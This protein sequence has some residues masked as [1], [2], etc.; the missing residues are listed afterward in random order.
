MR[1]PESTARVACLFD[2]HGNLP[3]LEAVLQEVRHAG[4]DRVVVGGDVL[5]GPMP[6]QC[7]DLLSSLDT[8]TSFIL[9]NG[10]LAALDARRGVPDARIPAAFHQ[11]MAWNGAQLTDA[12]AQAIQA[13]PLTLT[14]SID[15]A[16]DVLFCHATPRDVNEIFLKTTAEEKL[17]PLFDPLCVALVVC[18]HT[19]M[20]FDR[21]A[22]PT[23]VVNAGSIGM[24]FQDAGA[25]WAV[26][27]PGVELRRTAYD[28]DSAAARVRAT[29][30]PHAELAAN[31]ILN[32][33]S[34]QATLEQF[35]AAE[36]K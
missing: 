33:P 5:P 29:A 12:D 35:A 11:A 1:L 8:P 10:D 3:A 28:L 2:I 19:H 30:Y 26:I 24:P 18:G 27:G 25:Y 15:G 7:L 31:A 13:W 6:R 32:P 34:E 36:L 9:G 23:R 22:G 14:L 16:G 20:Q 4:V 17:R 21:M